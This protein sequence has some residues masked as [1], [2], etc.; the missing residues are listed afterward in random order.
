MMS[1]MRTTLNI[2]DD[3]IRQLKREVHKTNSP[4]CRLVN[5]ALRKGMTEIQPRRAKKSYTCPVFSMGEPKVNL[6]KALS[7]VA[8]LE[9]AEVLREM[10]LRK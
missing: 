2:D 6:N 5:T 7:L 8:S 1:G 10:E 9:D 3:L 4:L